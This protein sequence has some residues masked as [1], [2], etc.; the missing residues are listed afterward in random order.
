[1]SVSLVLRR[2]NFYHKDRNQESDRDPS[3]KCTKRFDRREESFQIWPASLTNVFEDRFDR[4]ET[5]CLEASVLAL[6]KKLRKLISIM[7]DP[8]DTKGGRAA[9]ALNFVFGAG[10]KKL[11]AVPTH[12][13]EETVEV[14]LTNFSGREAFSNKPALR[15]LKERKSARTLAAANLESHAATPNSA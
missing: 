1:L 6:A 5:P 4:V 14:G 11:G 10:D 12:T 7:P 9:T 2:K 8:E 13:P 15:N 3:Y